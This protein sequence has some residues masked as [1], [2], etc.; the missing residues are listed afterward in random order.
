MYGAPHFV[1]AFED[2]HDVEGRCDVLWAG[3]ARWGK[4]C[5][6]PITVVGNGGVHRSLP[7]VAMDADRAAVVV[8]QEGRDD[9]TI[10]ARC[11]AVDGAER[12]ELVTVASGGWSHRT[13][14]VAMAP[15]GDVVVVWQVVADGAAEIHARGLGRQG[16]ERFGEIVVS[17]GTAGVPGAPAV[18]MDAAGRFVVVWGEL[19]DESLAV[20]ARGFGAD[21]SERFGPISVADG[22]GDQDVFPRVAMASDGGFVVV[23]E[24]RTRDVRAVGYSPD[25]AERFPERSVSGVDAGDQ[26]LADLAAPRPVASRSYGP[27]T[28]T[29]TASARSGHGHST[30]TATR[31]SLSSLPTRGAGESSCDRGSPSTERVGPT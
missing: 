1:A 19:A 3:L 16:Q 12:F 25:G 10:R 22:L 11:L 21:G 7:N 23:F 27:M 17:G 4:Y 14:D 8:W 18:S 13:P 9:G 24:R 6:Q 2:D 30:P 20:C 15:G 26:L 29:R 28:A 31:L 5:W